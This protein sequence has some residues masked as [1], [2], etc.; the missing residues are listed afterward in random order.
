M[1]A[2]WRVR[3]RVTLGVDIT[4]CLIE[5]RLLDPAINSALLS[6]AGSSKAGHSNHICTAHLREYAFLLQG[7]C[8]D[9]PPPMKKG[10]VAS[11][12]AVLSNKIGLPSIL[13]DIRHESTHHE[14]PSLPLL[15]LGSAQALQWLEDY[16]CEQK[17]SGILTL[18]W[19]SFTQAGAKR[20][21]GKAGGQ[22]AP[23]PVEEEAGEMGPVEAIYI[24][25]DGERM[26][27]EL[28]SQ[29]KAFLPPAWTPLMLNSFL[30]SGAMD[31]PTPKSVAAG[32]P[33]PKDPSVTS[34]ELGIAE[35]AWVAV[36]IEVFKAYPRLRLLLIQGALKRLCDLCVPPPSSTCTS[37][38]STT[39]NSA[40]AAKSEG[41]AVKST[42]ARSAEAYL[43]WIIRLVPPPP[44]SASAK[45]AAAAKG[46][47]VSEPSF[48][49]QQTSYLLHL[50]DSASAK[51]AA[52]KKAAAAK[53]NCSGAKPKR[54]SAVIPA[55]KTTTPVQE[56]LDRRQLIQLLTDAVQGT[57]LVTGFILKVFMSTTPMQ[58]EL[59]RRQLIQLLTDAV[60]GTELALGQA[61]IV[62]SALLSSDIKSSPGD[63]THEEVTKAEALLQLGSTFLQATALSGN[64]GPGTSDGGSDGGPRASDQGGPSAPLPPPAKRQRT[65]APPKRWRVADNWSAC[66]IGCLPYSLDINGRLPPLMGLPPKRA[67][68][69]LLA[70]LAEHGVPTD[71]GLAQQGSKVGAIS[72]N[73]PGVANPD[74]SP[75]LTPHLDPTP[76][77]GAE[78]DRHVIHVA[79]ASGPGFTV[80]PAPAAGAG[81]GPT[82]EPPTHIDTSDVQGGPAVVPTTH[83]DTS[84]GQMGDEFENEEEYQEEEEDGLTDYFSSFGCVGEER[85]EEGNEYE[86]AWDKGG[87][88]HG[89]VLQLGKW[90]L[91]GTDAEH[92]KHSATFL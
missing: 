80:Q 79:G 30:D 34:K 84:N 86:G 74:T 70:T 24:R 11:S 15:R 2:V 14:M 41:S 91:A 31:P 50:K 78:E 36:L 53:S 3:G 51:K 33:R 17:I 56:K 29:L 92:L 46:N 73:T 22:P 67:P 49:V 35:Q 18:L 9:A 77:G 25:A 57:E 48:R 61:T 60:Q 89:G 81:G 64:R 90:H 63:L 19:E 28:V 26:Q 1:V 37:G 39:A 47:C 20:A 13:V 16:Y 27:R 85:A 8:Q 43:N 75:S 10:R 40:C 71:G 58:E 52:A 76:L 4:A 21:K 12:V 82:F 59:D 69:P 44:E 88:S 62:L 72:R 5:A 45:K 7:G 55:E 83:M 23:P 6:S 54:K 38:S 32:G 66:G 42:P 65:Q 68:E 87:G